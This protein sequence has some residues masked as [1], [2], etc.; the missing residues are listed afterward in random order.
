MEAV[1]RSSARVSL[2]SI[3]IDFGAV[4][5]WAIPFVLF[6]YLALNNGGYD[7]VERSE[8]GI[9]L[10]WLVLIGSLFGALGTIRGSRLAPIAFAFLLAYAIWTAIALTWT[11]S[12]ERTMVE[13]GRVAA[14]LGA[15][16]LAATAQAAGRWRAL[17]GGVTAAVGVIVVLAALSRMQPDLF[18]AQTAAAAFPGAG[19]ESR[20]AYP[21]NYSTG[22][23]ALAA[24]TIPLLLRAASDARLIGLQGLAA[25]VIPI[26]FL[27]L[28][29]TGSS[30]S[31]PLVAIA[32]VSYLILAA[33]RLPAL[34]TLLVGGVGGA[35]LIVASEQRE[36]LAQGLT[37][38]NATAQGDQLLA[39][40]LVVAIAAGL[41]GV[42]IG[43]ANRHGNRPG[44]LTITRRRAASITVLAV[45]VCAVG[46]AL[47]PGP[48][49]LDNLWND[50]R[51]GTQVEAGDTSRVAQILDPS[52]R[53]RFKFW[54]SGIDAF[55]TDPL[56]GI[57]PGTFEFW[58]AEHGSD[59]E[60]V[61]D[62]HSLYIESLAELGLPGALMIVGFVLLAVFGGGVRAL[63]AGGDRR[64]AIA[65]ATAAAA[66][67][68]V[69]AAV[70]W[71]WELGALSFLFVVLAAVALG[72]RDEGPAPPQRATPI[73]P[74]LAIAGLAVA[75][76]VVIAIPLAGAEAVNRSQ[77]AALA[78]QSD[79]ALADADDGAALQPYAATPAL[80][81]ALLLEGQGRFNE[82][83]VA[84]GVAIDNEPENWR[85]WLTLSRIQ[86]EAGDARAAVASYRKARSL[87]PNSGLFA[88]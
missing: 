75:G 31:I 36:A 10:W 37:N 68:S 74:R 84:A 40:A 6:I 56:K 63:R 81:R 30:L 14:L 12:D 86:A 62:A 61:R 24:M 88:Q 54:E 39:V 69:A 60:F 58:W 41:L 13:V 38:A 2:G 85:N 32:L 66:V 19:L 21:L 51:G 80:Q 33:N 44:W 53:G 26:A 7:I 28:W 18:P 46:F 8:I 82:A 3:R 22:V 64:G 77:T 79:A 65:A 42:A 83:A 23:A 9:A 72:A 20:L 73:L 76:L 45:L 1:E 34:L 11:G 59:S 4:A 55:Q 35:I 29:L 5:A 15:F 47:S 17:L 25:G 48:G 43:L 49:K 52:S 50:F 57:G 78:G 87:N 27:T 16:T 71:M 70:D 67:F